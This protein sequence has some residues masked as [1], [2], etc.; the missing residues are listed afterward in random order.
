MRSC[1]ELLYVWLWSF[2][3]AVVVVPWPA[4]AEMPS[5]ADAQWIWDD[6]E[7]HPLNCFLMFRKN[8][9]LPTRPDAALLHIT[10]SDRY[11]LYI[12][13]E[14]V[15][16][17]PARSDPRFK[18]YDTHQIG[19]RLKSG[20]NVLAVL[21]Y[22][23]GQ[24]TSESGPYLGNGYA[25][26]DRAGLWAK[27]EIAGGA[28]T[29]VISTGPDWLLTPALGWKRDVP[30]V[31]PLVGF[32][33]WYD[34]RRDPLDWMQPGFDD[35]GWQPATVI[36]EQ[37][38]PW[39]SL[40]VRDVPTMRETEVF[41]V[42]IAKKGE[43]AE[44]AE[45][46]IHKRF[47]REL[48]LPL[49]H[50]VLESPKSL[51]TDDGRA[52]RAHANVAPGGEVREPFV[53]LDF[54]RQVFGFPRIKMTAPE[55]T[56]ID[57]I[58]S[59]HLVDSRIATGA[60]HLGSRYIA[61]EGR[62]TW[63]H[64]EY[65]QFRYLQ[66]AVRGHEPVMIESVSLNAYEYPA[67]RRG[68]FE[69]SDPVLTK[70]W[71]AC[72]D[73]AYL[74]MEDVLAIDAWRERVNWIS[75]DIMDAA[76]AGFGDTAVVRRH[77]R[78]ISRTDFG[79]GLL[80]VFVPPRHIRRRVIP[81]HLLCWLCQ[82]KSHYDCVGDR[83]FLA[84]LYPAVKGQMNWFDQILDQDGMITDM[85]MWNWFDWSPMDTRGTCFANNA[86]YSKALEACAS[87]ADEM[88]DRESASRWREKANRVREN[89]RT[90]F[91]NDEQGLFE[92][93]FVKDK[94][95]ESFSEMANGL[96][97]WCDLATPEQSTRILSRFHVQTPEG[98]AKPTPIHIRFILWGLIRAGRL[99]KAVE[100]MRG[101]Y[102]EMIEASDAPTIR[103][104]WT[105]SPGKTRS[106]VHG[107]NIPAWILSRDVLGIKSDGPGFKQCRIDVPDLE[108]IDWAKGVFPSVRGDIAV[109]WR[110]EGR[111]LTVDVDLPAG[112]KTTIAV[113]RDTHGR[114]VTLDGKPVS[115]PDL[116]VVGGKHRVLVE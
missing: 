116:I 35:S 21:A 20:K 7:P 61:R 9:E 108:S 52:A 56:I 91:F 67:Q 62:Q 83:D 6:G 5:M 19:E 90:R 111:Q 43:V 98:I 12:N 97:L 22:H 81:Q 48:H 59:P 28:E 75:C 26:G 30:P 73:T 37:Q 102:R 80:A 87:L 114:V 101:R 15:G 27:L 76:A 100:L 99:D 17:G 103:E 3:A 79:D 92:D 95:T 2:A 45:N 14:Y 110:K 50:A 72:V 96:A 32:P 10:A 112:L 49:E 11:V 25:G 71:T 106:L 109:H 64:F 105:E 78:M 34:A 54:G 23:Y 51:L 94:F 42:R 18:S 38:R 68:R 55:G 31:N 46:H 69:C 13:G 84:E 53:I 104:L 60:M 16:R 70:L 8:L 24:N 29:T 1:K 4:A 85:P 58:T 113:A 39:K 47:M 93:A 44:V 36:P 66:I 115:T 107:G 57:V 65:R 89:L 88:N 33:E 41:P 63:Q 40:E 77:F 74:Q 82:I 86:V